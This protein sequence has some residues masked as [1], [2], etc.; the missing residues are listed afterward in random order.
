MTKMKKTL[1]L[2]IFSIAIF[3]GL[4]AFAATDI[5]FD[6]SDLTIDNG[7]EFAV[8]IKVNP[9]GEKNYTV[10][11]Q[12]KYP[13]FLEVKD[14]RFADNWIGVS[15]VGYDRVDNES[16]ILVKT[17]GY[18]KGFN[19][20][21]DFGTVIFSAKKPGSGLLEFDYLTFSLDKDGKNRLGKA[22]TL[23]VNVSG[24]EAL[25]GEEQE[26]QIEGA[27]L[28]APEE[29]ETSLLPTQ[30]FDINLEIERAEISDAK[31][32]VARMIFTS[33]GRVPTPVDLTF[34]ILNDKG[35]KIYSK[36]DK[37]TVETQAVLTERF[38]D[39]EKDL[40]P[41]KYTLVVTTLYNKDV[42][43]EFKQDFEIVPPEK[44]KKQFWKSLWFWI[45][46]T[47]ILIAIFVAALKKVKNKEEIK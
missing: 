39:I 31:D 28:T 9:Q 24:K 41:G 12:I 35:E 47:I 42:K 10:R 32:L 22:N 11:A 19:T 44:I 13:D 21:I 38:K 37:I 15:Q 17:A 34:D 20:E 18:P 5:V 27:E 43:D 4:P 40:G 25:P 7:N 46:S 23:S 45:I 30:L 26:V 2:L 1:I 14:W 33:F 6:S 16:G 8:K 36:T 29:I 3:A